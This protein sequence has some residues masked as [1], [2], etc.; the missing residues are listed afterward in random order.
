[1]DGMRKLSGPVD[2]ELQRRID[3]LQL[4]YVHAIDDGALDTW[5]GFFTDQCLY[6][7]VSRDNL[8]RGQELGVMRFESAAMLRDRATATQ[9]A[10]VFAPRT[11][12]HI[13]NPTLVDQVDDDGIRTRTNVTIYQTSPD[14]D[15]SLLVAGQY[16]DWIVD[17]DGE[18]K[19]REKRMVYDTF[20]LPDSIVYPL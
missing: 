8:E 18:L 12:R 17:I 16:R 2:G 3:H 1:M 9:H 4:V 19:F 14:G 5:P 15:T 7:I 13:L 10:A 6:T 20:C 11:I